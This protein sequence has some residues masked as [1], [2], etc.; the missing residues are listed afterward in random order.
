MIWSGIAWTSFVPTAFLISLLP[1]ANQLL[2]VRNAV[3][4]G[5]GDALAGL[6]GRL[7][8]FVILIVIVAAGMGS[9]LTAS[10]AAFGA[11]TW[12]G[13]AYLAW[14]GFVALLN[15]SRTTAAFAPMPRSRRALTR[16]EFLVAITN[17]KAL[18]LFAVILPQFISASGEA[19]GRLLFVGLTYLAIE[20]TVSSGYALLGARLRTFTTRTA[21]GCID[22]ISGLMFLGLA[23]YLALNGRV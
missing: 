12:L 8:G 4:Q 15:A 5:S 10:P 7:G 2:I 16:Q 3:R 17:P 11:M 1:G 22:R 6:A 23:V 20:A 14:F 13:V 9:V 21:A 18:L 19:T